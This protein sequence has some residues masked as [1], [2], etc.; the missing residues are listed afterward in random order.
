MGMSKLSNGVI[1]QSLSCVLLFVTPWTVAHQ[2]VFCIS[3]GD[4]FI[5]QV[6]E[7]HSTCC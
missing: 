1:V 4:S 7:S 2:G 3:N 5:L 6:N